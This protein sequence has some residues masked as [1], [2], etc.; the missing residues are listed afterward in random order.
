MITDI[1]PLKNLTQLTFLSLAWN[2][3]TDIAALEDMTELRELYINYSVQNGPKLNNTHAISELTKLKLI[4]VA[5][6]D[7]DEISFVSTLINCNYMTLNFNSITNITGISN[8]NKLYKIRLDNNNLS[9]ITPLEE[10]VES[11]KYLDLDDNQIT[12][13][14]P[15]VKNTNFGQGDLI[16]ISRNP[17]DEISRNQ[18]IPELRKR[19]VVVTF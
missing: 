10:G 17:L 9:D 18:Y 16:F 12:N 14:E 4:W 1:S 7:I 5:D 15:L 13:I 11:L 6:Y 2:P 8:C 3:I 19:G